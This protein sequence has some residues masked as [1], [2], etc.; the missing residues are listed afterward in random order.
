MAASKIVYFGLHRPFNVKS[1]AFLFKRAMCVDTGLDRRNSF[2]IVTKTVHAPPSAR[3]QDFWGNPAFKEGQHFVAGLGMDKDAKR[4]HLL[5]CQVMA[6]AAASYCGNPEVK[7]GLLLL[8]TAVGF[9]LAPSLC[10]HGDGSTP[11]LAVHCSVYLLPPNLRAYRAL[12]VLYTVADLAH[13][14]FRPHFGQPAQITEP[15]EQ[16]RKVAIAKY[17]ADIQACPEYA[18]LRGKTFRMQL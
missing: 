8:C 9:S 13:P 16:A 6:R 17:S 12:Y 11:F 3:A 15:D 7:P 1:T 10:M 18:L 14:S 5:V 4:P 2:R